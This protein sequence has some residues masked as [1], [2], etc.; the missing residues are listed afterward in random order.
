MNSNSRNY[1]INEFGI[2]SS[3]INISNEVEKE[4]AE[5]IK[6]IDYVSEYNQIKVIRAMQKNRLSDSHFAGTTGY[7]YNDRGREVLDA[8]YADIFKAE[9]ALVRHQIVSGTQAL[10]VSMFGILR[11]GDELLSVT[12]KPYDTLEEVIGIRGEGGGSLKEFGISYN[13]VDLLPDGKL[14]FDGIRRAIGD[15]TKLVLIQRSRGYAWRPAIMIDDIARAVSLI[16]SIKKDAVVLV[17]NC[18]GEFVE[19]REPTEAGADMVAG[20]LIKNIG[21]GLAPTGGY[22]V[23]KAECVE[24]AAYRLTTPGLG[25]EVGSTLGNN[26]LMFQ[27]LFMA[28]HV[29]AESLKGAVYCAAIM[30]RLGFET[31]P[32]P[33]EKRGDIIQAIKFNNPDSLIAF[34]QGI[35]KGSPV[36]SFATPEPWDMPGYDCPVI[37]AAGAF[38]QGAS[39]ELSADAPIKP[40]YIAYMQG[41]L[42]YESVKLGV[43]SSIQL[44]KDRG[45]VKI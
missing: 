19:D 35:Q 5:V 44:M 34:C 12:G 27:G 42:V 22:I 37:M 10:A 31:S 8:V 32:M 6:E 28:P 13:Q 9:D 43:M 29:V 26:R 39:I 40:P 2:S 1:F 15:K 11:P 4:I 24:K 36:D 17:D 21:G 18:Y 23:G 14:D 20:S 41:G 25:K 45:I 33:T 16:K 7:G 38:I 30:N 3:I